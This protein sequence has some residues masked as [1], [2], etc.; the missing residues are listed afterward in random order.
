MLISFLLFQTDVLSSDDILNSR[1]STYR[2]CDS[3]LISHPQCL[4][5]ARLF[6]PFLY[7]FARLGANPFRQDFSA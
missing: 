5:L 6:S 3:G 1:L 4:P 7:L 2:R